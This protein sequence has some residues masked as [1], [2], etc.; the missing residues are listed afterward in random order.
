MLLDR[1]AAGDVDAVFA[2]RRGAYERAGRLATGHLHRLALAR[3]TGLP[4][5]AGAY[6]AL[7]PAARRAALALGGPSV[8]AAVGIAGVPTTSIP[9]DRQARPVGRSAWTG[10]ARLHQS[11]RTLLWAASR[12]S[13]W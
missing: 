8:V 5:D 7:R 1:L 9:V 2:G 4:K 10:A 13:G 6:M 11:A 12:R 3:L